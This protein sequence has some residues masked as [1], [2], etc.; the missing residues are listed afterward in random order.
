M[1]MRL[2]VGRSTGKSHTPITPAENA[3]YQ[4]IGELCSGKDP[5]QI[6]RDLSRQ[7]TKLTQISICL[8][9]DMALSVPG[10]HL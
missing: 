10:K 2:E 1:F 8:P 5:K 3:A 4:M 6:Q 7:H 9:S